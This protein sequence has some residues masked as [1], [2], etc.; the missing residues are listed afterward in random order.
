MQDLYFFEVIWEVACLRDGQWK[1]GKHIVRSAVRIFSDSLYRFG[2]DLLEVEDSCV[3]PDLEELVGKAKRNEQ[4]ARPE[5]GARKIPG[6]P[7]AMVASHGRPISPKQ[8][9]YELW[10]DSG[11]QVFKADLFFIEPLI[12]CHAFKALLN[13]LQ[14]KDSPEAAE[15]L[16]TLDVLAARAQL[17]VKKKT[18]RI[19][20]VLTSEAGVTGRKGR[21]FGMTLYGALRHASAPGQ[22]VRYALLLPAE[23]DFP[24]KPLSA[25]Q[26]AADLPL[27]VCSGEPPVMNIRA[28][29]DP[30]GDYVVLPLKPGEEEPEEPAAPALASSFLAYMNF[31]AEPSGLLWIF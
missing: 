15:D 3:G 8:T 18:Q 26:P 23:A 21:T 10:E 6:S 4:S 16:G 1:T 12:L 17:C 11:L 9:L 25:G 2:P 31:A 27:R 20:T 7:R 19:E 28:P 29:G 13:A 22:K 5:A 14:G 24:G 30:G